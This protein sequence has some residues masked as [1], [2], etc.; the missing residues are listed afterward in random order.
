M[1]VF[2][3]FGKGKILVRE[4]CIVLE[5]YENNKRISTKIPIENLEILF[6]NGLIGFSPL[7]LH[8][9]FRKKVLTIFIDD[10]KGVKGV[11][12]PIEKLFSTFHIFQYRA[13]IYRRLEIAKAIIESLKAS[14]VFS[15]NILQ[16]VEYKNKLEDV[17]VVGNTIQEIMGAESKIWRIIYSYLKNE[18]ID[19]EERIYNPPIG[20]MNALISYGNAL[21]YSHI[22]LKLLNHKFNTMIGFLH[23]LSEGRNSL[24]LDVSESFKPVFILLLDLKLLKDR[25]I[26]ESHFEDRDNSTYLNMVGKVL[27]TNYFE[28]FLRMKFIKT[29][30]GRKV[31]IDWM[32]ESEIKNLKNAIEKEN[33][34][35]SIWWEVCSLY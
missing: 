19:F 9:I 35:S 1:N 8:K 2:Y 32:I 3:V 6:C 11:I 34:F 4:R 28:R 25:I 12:V 23:E 10:F 7:S 5:K 29:R 14:A 24:A 16:E 30:S 33:K 15:F 17:E 21:L 31:S 26:N 22:T 18:G 27:Y 20:K 13:Y